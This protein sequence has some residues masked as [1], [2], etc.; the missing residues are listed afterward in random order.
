[1]LRLRNLGLRGRLLLLVSLAVLPAL[2]LLGAQ[3]FDR[4]RQQADELNQSVLN[5]ARLV[6]HTQ[7]RRLEGTRQL[8]VAMSRSS[9]IRSDRATCT[10]YVRELVGQ[11]GGIYRQIGWADTSG[12][13]MCHALE[14][15]DAISIADRSYFTQ[16]Q[17][18]GGFTVGEAIQGRITGAPALAF[19][20]ALSSADGDFQGVI[21]ASIDLRL[22][23]RSL[24]EEWRTESTTVTILDRHG[25]IL[26]RAPET[27][28]AI[29]ARAS[30]SQ[31]QVMRERG[32]LVRHFAGAD[33]VMRVYGIVA[34]RDA[35]GGDPVMF[36]AVGIRRDVLLADIDR[37]LRLDLLIFACLGLGI[38]GAAW[39]AVEWLI[40]RP[41]TRLVGA[42]TQ[43]ASGRLETRVG[44]IAS[45]PELAT[46]GRAFD[47]M[48]GKLQQRDLH[49][50][51]G[52]RLEAVG[53]LA[54]GIAHDFNNLLTV[55]VGYGES[56]RAHIPEGSDAAADLSELRTAAERASALTHQLL[57]FSRRQFLQP[58]PLVVN[59]TLSGMLSL[60][61]RTM[62]GEIRVV[63]ELDPAVGV[64]LADPAQIEQVILNL[65]INARDAMPQGGEVRFETVNASIE[66]EHRSSGVSVP[67]GQYVVLR[68]SDTGIG[69]S[70]AVRERIFEPFFTT[71]G[72]A[73][74]GLGLATVYGIVKQSGG[75]VFCDS[76]PGRGTQFTIY[77][78]RTSEALPEAAR[79]ER[80][81]PAGGTESIILVDDEDSVCRLLA[82]VLGRKGYDV[83]STGLA[84]EAL[85][86]IRAGARAD[87]LVT[88]VRMAGMSGPQLVEHVSALRPD[89]RVLFISGYAS[90]A[91]GG[92]A[93]SRQHSFLQKPFTPHDLLVRVRELLP[94]ALRETAVS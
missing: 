3:A 6:A 92:N 76:A 12:R 9:E 78:P 37:R 81:A 42:T 79:E 44:D 29:A 18:N 56:L 82:Q 28:G 32:E 93:V 50:R 22:F 5:L 17:R 65:A 74:T 55:I 19:A 67:H 40:R 16:A 23:G 4:R 60:L 25:V 26:A 33:G 7:E 58:R 38:L 75:F 54:G 71:K 21:F 51:Q 63:T 66:E 88:D 86:W 57:A 30:R 31:V 14:G 61:E 47:D 45:V 11:Y 91:P 27:D 34:V 87:L 43:L 10:R 24:R 62:G 15:A 48:A 1:M 8:L 70:D 36:V 20:H 64:V 2:G 46:L 85:E 94:N 35:S 80:P 41:V 73:G 49:L 83:R 59:E 90:D 84:H 68:V 52:Q 69:M 39:G 77:L 72:N 89:L 53:Q 13:V